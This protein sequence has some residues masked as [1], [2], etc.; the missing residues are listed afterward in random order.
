MNLSG[1]DCSVIVQIKSRVLEQDK[2]K[3]QQKVSWYK[4]SAFTVKV[5]GDH[6]FMIMIVYDHL[7]RKRSHFCVIAW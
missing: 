2:N 6:L 7:T 3:R 5:R 1:S 4:H